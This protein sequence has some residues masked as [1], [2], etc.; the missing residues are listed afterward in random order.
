MGSVTKGTT[1]SY[2]F[3]KV[4]LLTLLGVALWLSSTYKLSDFTQTLRS[5]L[6][7]EPRI[8]RYAFATILTGGNDHDYPEVNEPYFEA[9]RLLNFQILHNP[10]TQTHIDGVPFLVLVTP[11]VPSK[12]RDMLTR[13]G[14]TVI[15][16]ENISH[17]WS[18]PEWK[19]WHDKLVR[20]NLWRLEDYDKIIFFNADTI[21]FNQIDDLFRYSGT[22]TRATSNPTRNMPSQYMIAGTHDSWT[23]WALT[24]FP[25]QDFYDGENYMDKGFFVLRPSKALFEYYMEILSGWGEFESEYPEQDLLNYAHRLDGPMPWQQLG[26]GW[27][28]QSATKVEYENGLRSIR[29]KWWLQMGDDFVGKKVGMAMGQMKA[30]L[31]H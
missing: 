14:A 27:N 25:D 20:L 30:Y 28:A 3:K 12:H 4:V 19:R 5:T 26:P 6:R 22:A 15:P 7:S 21:L 11:D 2:C 8:P 10:R 31:N 23:E 13:E 18:C 16:I 9:A 1:R 17:D 24:S 29:H